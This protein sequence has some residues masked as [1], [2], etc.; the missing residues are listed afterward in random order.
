[1]RGMPDD[2]TPNEPAT[3]MSLGPES[4]GCWLGETQTSRHIWDLD[5]RTYRRLRGS[6]EPRFPHDDQIVKITRV[7]RRRR[8]AVSAS[9]GST[10][11]RR[12]PEC[13]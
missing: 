4:T 7:E 1:M 11:L 10:R 5:Q 2:R 12:P 13:P 8:L 6:A 3:V 9:A